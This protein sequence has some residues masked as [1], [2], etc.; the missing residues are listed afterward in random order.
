MG[1]D[2][3]TLNKAPQ[4]RDEIEKK[5]ERI[6][7]SG[8]KNILSIRDVDKDPN[9]EYY[10]V[11]TSTS[12]GMGRVDRFR[13]GGWEIVPRSSGIDF[14]DRSV[15]KGTLLGS[16]VTHTRGGQTLVLMAIPKEW[17]IEDQKAK[18]ER[19]DALEAAMNEELRQG[20]FPGTGSAERGSYVPDGGG[21]QI[22][23]K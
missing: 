12:E 22:T 18:Q 14:G 15:D 2:T 6:P 11:N 17:W 13:D 10:W 4:K 5:R 9:K 21:L 3:L 20:R 23:R 19:V 16:A 7:V 8:L 1:Q